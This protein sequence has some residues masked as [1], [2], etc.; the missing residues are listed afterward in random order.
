[1][2]KEAIK[3][4][5]INQYDNFLNKIQKPKAKELWDNK[6]DEEWENL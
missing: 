5:K 2:K 4:K 6:K 1:M 3:S